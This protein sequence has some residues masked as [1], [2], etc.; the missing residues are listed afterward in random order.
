M[1]LRIRVQVPAQ[2]WPSQET[3]VTRSELNFPIP[4]KHPRLQDLCVRK[5]NRAYI[6]PTAHQATH[7][8]GLLSECHHRPPE[9]EAA[10]LS[11][12]LH[13]PGRV[14][15]SLCPSGQAVPPPLGTL[16]WTVPCLGLGLP[17]GEATGGGG[18]IDALLDQAQWE[19][20]VQGPGWTPTQPP[21]PPYILWLPPQLSITHPRPLDTS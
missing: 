18:P 17:N 19:H 7:P 3:G 21:L 9:S 15:A 1:S 20:R 5:V 16:V 14:S 13:F 12:S 8:R 6:W 10:L 2:S 11:G 4:I